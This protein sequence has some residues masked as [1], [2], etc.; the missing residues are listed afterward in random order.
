MLRCTSIASDLY[1]AGLIFY[2][3]L[4]GELPFESIDQMMEADGKFPIKPSEHKPDLP[5]GVDEWLQNF[6]EF[7][8]ED[9]YNSA[10]I[11]Q[12]KLDE[13]ILPE[14][15]DESVVAPTTQQIT[16]DLTNL[17]QDFILADRF[18]IQKKLGSGGFCVAYKVF[19]SFG[20]VVRVIKLVIKDRRSV[21]ERLRREYKTLTNLPDH[22]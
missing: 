19:D 5:K 22:P 7:D 14:A 11:V 15:K 10:A 18:R 21:Y 6:C 1:A 13:L 17:P 4:T 2:E 16:D 20:D 12:K 3:L 8:Q 9:R